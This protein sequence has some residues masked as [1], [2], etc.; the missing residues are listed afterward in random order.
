MLRGSGGSTFVYRH[1]ERA[2]WLE[3]EVET[4]RLINLVSESS[5]QRKSN[6]VLSLST[7]AQSAVQ[8]LI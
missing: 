2:M 4:S 3:P 6:K 8:I 7:V 1:V 5:D